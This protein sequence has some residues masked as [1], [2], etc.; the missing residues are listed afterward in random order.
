M[1]AF[2]L[3]RKVCGCSAKPSPSRLCRAPLTAGLEMTSCIAG[4]R[5]VTFSAISSLSGAC[6]M[7]IL[8]S[9]PRRKLLLPFEST[10]IPVS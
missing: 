10:S 7:I 4:M 5:D 2:V 9:G 6:S 3:C 8:P 1:P